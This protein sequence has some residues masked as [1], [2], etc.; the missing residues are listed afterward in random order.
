[1]KK[2]LIIIVLM[3]IGFRA[4]AQDFDLLLKAR[5]LQA[6]ERLNEVSRLEPD[7]VSAVRYYNSLV[8]LAYTHFINIPDIVIKDRLYYHLTIAINNDALDI[9][10]VMSDDKMSIDGVRIDR[11]PKGFTVMTSQHFGNALINVGAIDNA[12]IPI[13]LIPLNDPTG[14]EFVA[15]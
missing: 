1:M 11:L 13:L 6:S 14:V 10:Y 8:D 2:Y 12:D 4:Y 3:L 9:V 5:A 7:Q 15:D